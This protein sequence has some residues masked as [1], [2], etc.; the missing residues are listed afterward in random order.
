MSKPL[1]I[2]SINFP[3]QS[4]DV[5]EEGTLL[6]ERALFDFDVVVIRP[7][8]FP[9]SR[10][11]QG[12]RVFNSVMETKRI[13][14]DRL[15]Q[16]GGVLVVI[17][18]APDIY[19]VD[20]GGYS[21]STKYEANNYQ[22][23]RH[24]FVASVRSGIGQQINYSDPGEPFVSVLKK[25]TVAW[26]AY[27][28]SIPGHPFN[29]LKFF[30]SAGAGTAIAGKMPY[31]EGHLV[32]LPNLKQLDEGSFFEAC[33]EYRYKRQGSTPPDWVEGVSLPG[34]PVIQDKI[35]DL[36]KQ[37]SELQVARSEAEQ[38]L[39]ARSAYLKLLYEKGKAQLEPIVLRALDDLGFGTTPGEII[40]GTNYEIDGRTKNGSMDG[41]VEVKGS[42]KQIALD[43][44]S[45]FVIKIL[46]DQEARNA[47]S[48]GI[49]VGNSLCE[50]KPETRLGDLVFSPH[51]L[52]AAKRNSVALINSTEL[53]CLCCT[54]LDGVEVDEAAIREAIINSN[55]FVDL[56]PFCGVPPWHRPGSV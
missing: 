42:R 32:L 47:I 4:R 30:A 6:T 22:F 14:L 13:E 27:L 33:A 29:D 9:A 26:T 38:E 7:E 55:G 35:N 54:L 24:D 48:K 16:Q 45:P 50:T 37:I 56:K 20:T 18:D 23:L 41:I 46:A 11:Y 39:Q 28:S 8:Q 52:E 19:R 44:F 12:Y 31:R 43:E 2:L 10:D 3:F 34:I 40:Q 51:V 1:R 21:S 36:N 53:F 49:L 15:F 17:L 25:S 5:V